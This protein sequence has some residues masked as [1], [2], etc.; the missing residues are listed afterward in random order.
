MSRRYI[1]IKQISKEI[2]LKEEFNGFSQVAIES[3]LK[4][5]VFL[6]RQHLLNYESVRV[7]NLIGLTISVF[8]EGPRTE[9]KSPITHPSPNYKIRITLD[10]ELKREVQSLPKIEEDNG[11][12]RDSIMTVN[13]IKK[14]LKLQNNGKL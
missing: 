4:N 7:D 9:N 11:Y 12:I 2:F 14:R 8:H 13:R 1:T 5:F 6:A 10:K 3:I